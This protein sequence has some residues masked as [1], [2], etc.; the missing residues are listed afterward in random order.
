M[1]S[2]M[3]RM[4]FYNFEDEVWYKGEDGNVG[5]LTDDSKVVP[6]MIERIEQFYPKAY[7]ALCEEYSKCKLNLKYYRFKIV[8]RFCKCN[9]GNIDNVPDFKNGVFNFERV[10]CPLRGEC[11]LEGVV[12]SPEFENKLSQAELRVMR[13]ISQSKTPE[14]IADELYLSVYTVRNHLR[15]IYS[16]LGIHTRQ[17]LMSYIHNNNMFKDE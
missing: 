7:S 17:E 11:R 5:K 16:R 15:N 2:S 6:V 13:L 8:N 4:E 3:E 14:E 12:C 9:F 10:P 1:V